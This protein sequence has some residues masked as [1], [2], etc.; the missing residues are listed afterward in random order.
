MQELPAAAVCPE[1]V[2]RLILVTGGSQRV[3]RAICEEL[4]RSGAR[5]AVHYHRSQSDAE[6]LAEQ[7]G[8][9]ALAVHADLR[10]SAATSAMFQALEA[11]VGR[12]DMLV[13][14][15]A[16][17][18]RTPFHAL[19]DQA[20]DEQLAVNLTAPQRCIR[21]AVAAGATAVV[22]L[23]DIAAWQPWS[24]Y[25]AYAVAKAGL[26]HLTRILARE[27]APT[28]RVNAVAPG[29]VIFPPDYDAAAQ[30]RV[31]AR[32]PLGRE[33]EPADVGR[34]VRFLLSEPYLTGVCLPVDGGQGLR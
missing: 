9:G 2:G 33:G 6:A 32:V 21:L 15:A 13:N 22:N 8:G 18:G 29:T 28:V 5:L 17:F 14:N 24:E 19:T 25:S 30:A 11:R 7:L 12:I 4:A 1:L 26:L 20:W 27:L 10:S 34:A 31:L 23:V 16:I 3:G